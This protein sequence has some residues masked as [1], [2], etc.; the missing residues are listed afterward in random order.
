VKSKANPQKVNYL[1]PIDKDTC[2]TRHDALR[3]VP[4]RERTL[5]LY[6]PSTATEVDSINNL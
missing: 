3:R 2:E 5:Q 1:V 4:A 6:S